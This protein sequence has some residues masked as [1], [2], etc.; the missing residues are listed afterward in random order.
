[1][2]AIQ[3]EIYYSQQLWMRHIINGLRVCWQTFYTTRGH[4]NIEMLSH[5][6]RISCWKDNTILQS[7][8]PHNRIS[9]THEMP[10]QWNRHWLWFSIN[11]IHQINPSH[12]IVCRM[13]L[14]MYHQTSSTSCMKSPNW[15]ISRLFC[16]CL[17]PISWSQMLS[18]EWRCSWSS[19]DRQ[20][21]NYVWVI[22]N[23][24]AY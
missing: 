24:I 3:Q 4:F 1:M 21:S 15:N 13:I 12:K 5:Q 19:A 7:P 6:H 23:F 17:C 20:C 8:C 18:Q 9:S 2:D 16:I 10:F 11:I 22:N 14:F